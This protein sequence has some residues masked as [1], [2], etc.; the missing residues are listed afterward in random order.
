MH[1]HPYQA[2]IKVASFTNHEIKLSELYEEATIGIKKIC[3][4]ILEKHT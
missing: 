3:R 1:K 2:Y 4:N